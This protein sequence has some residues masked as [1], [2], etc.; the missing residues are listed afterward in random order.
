MTSYR[1]LTP[2]D[3]KE[4]VY[5]FAR[6]NRKVEVVSYT[7]EEYN[8]VMNIVNSYEERKKKNVEVARIRRQKKREELMAGKG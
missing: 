1:L 4:E 8:K 3:E 6:F 5:P 2:P 7:E